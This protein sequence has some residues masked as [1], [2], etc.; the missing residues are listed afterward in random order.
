MK[1]PQLLT[2]LMFVWLS[3]SIFLPSSAVA[4]DRLENKHLKQL[5]LRIHKKTGMS[6]P[7]VGDAHFPSVVFVTQQF[8]NGMICKNKNCNAQAAAKDATVF[9]V[10]GLDVTTIEGESILYHELIHILQFY[11]FGATSTSDNWVQREIEAYQLQDEFVT[12]KGYD[13]PWLRSVTHYLS[14]MCP[15]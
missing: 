15:K 12:D 4:A 3:N 2:A 5:L 14:Q 8:I 11:N 10:N 7:E 6:V 1:S 13:M 9:L